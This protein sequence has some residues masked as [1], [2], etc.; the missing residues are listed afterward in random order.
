MPSALAPTLGS[1]EVDRQDRSRLPA[2]EADLSLPAPRSVKLRPSTETPLSSGRSVSASRQTTRRNTPAIDG[3]PS[4]QGLPLSTKSPN[5]ASDRLHVP[6][7]LHPSRPSSIRDRLVSQGR[8]IPELHLS[9]QAITPSLWVDEAI[10]DMFQQRLPP[11]TS[12]PAALIQETVGAYDGIRTPSTAGAKALPSPTLSELSDSMEDVQLARME[13]VERA[14]RFSVTPQL[15]VVRV[16]ASLTGLG[17]GL[18]LGLEDWGKNQGEEKIK[19]M[20]DRR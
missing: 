8:P 4:T 16:G 13:R 6:R 9:R 19:S 1:R 17:L 11:V 5:A 12:S 7:R 10:F 2:V 20:Y 3:R 18:G 14:E 15:P